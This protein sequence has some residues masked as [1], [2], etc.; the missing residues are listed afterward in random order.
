[1]GLTW[2]GD[3]AG[4]ATAVGAALAI[5]V[6][7]EDKTTW[8]EGAGLA[9]EVGFIETELGGLGAGLATEVGFIDTELGGPA[10]DG[11]GLD[12]GGAPYASEDNLADLASDSW[13]VEFGDPKLERPLYNSPPT[14]SNEPNNN[15][16]QNGRDLAGVSD[17]GLEYTGALSRSSSLDS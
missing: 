14:T 1:M 8:G 4:L 12:P 17:T 15:N 6:G 9:T 11:A 16:P 10:L 5:A 2:A 3:G 13:R 7:G